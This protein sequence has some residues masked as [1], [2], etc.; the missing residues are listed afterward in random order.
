M[1]PR[2]EAADLVLGMISKLRQQSRLDR[3]EAMRLVLR[4]EQKERQADCLAAMMEAASLGTD[5]KVHVDG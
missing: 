5:P 1:N 4:A 2:D 3:D